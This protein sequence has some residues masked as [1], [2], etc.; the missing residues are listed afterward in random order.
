MFA[1]AALSLSLLLQSAAPASVLTPEV[2]ADIASMAPEMTHS[3]E[4]LGACDRQF[5]ELGRTLYPL[6]NAPAE[7]AEAAAVQEY[8]RRTYERGKAS[9]QAATIKPETCRA[10]MA[11]LPEQ[12]ADFERRVNAAH[13][14]IADLPPE[15]TAQ[16]ENTLTIMTRMFET[17]GACE[18][19]F[20]PEFSAQMRANFTDEADADKRAAT[21]FLLE[22]Y[23][24]GKNSPRAAAL[25]Q[26]QCVAEMNLI[27]ADL[28][29]LKTEI[30]AA[31]ND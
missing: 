11:G 14:Q 2:E 18:R 1:A 3:M 9:P 16:L 8:I 10:T 4:I 27:D 29:S 26:E 13:F 24:R 22:A 17:L 15:Q 6:L 31:A 20:P 30:E 12:V 21:A 28:Q 5:P 19:V 7:T 23:D 25:T